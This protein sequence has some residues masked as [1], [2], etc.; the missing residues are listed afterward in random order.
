MRSS[1]LIPDIILMTDWY[2]Y[3]FMWRAM[4]G[5][6]LIGGLSSYYGVFVVQRR[7]SFLGSGLAHAAFGGVALGLLLETEPLLIAV[8]FTVIVAVMINWIRIH[9]RLAG[10]T[11]IGVLFAVSVSLGVIFLTLRDTGSVDAMSY[12][13][14]SILSVSNTDIVVLCGLV[15]VAG[16]SIKYLWGNWAYATFDPE[17]ARADG[18]VL[19]RDDYLLNILLAVTIV[20]SI[21]IVGILLIAAFLV[22][23]AASAR[24]LSRTFYQMTLTSMSIGI[25]SVITGLIL[26]Y[27]LDFPSGAVIILV[28]AAIFV[29]AMVRS[30]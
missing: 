12:L 18:L 24:L 1:L 28:Q 11:A 27:E 22:I 13:F 6:I 20:L 21:K 15:V 2:T 16:I 29:L 17:I 5:G 4:V 25:F 19:D 8:P 14:G 7:L 23:P 30:R 10:D 26:S 3:D 9:T